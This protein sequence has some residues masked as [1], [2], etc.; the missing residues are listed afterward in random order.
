MTVLT[1]AVK[2]LQ[3]IAAPFDVGAASPW[4]ASSISSIVAGARFSPIPHLAEKIDHI[5]VNGTSS[6][7]LLARNNVFADSGPG[8]SPRRRVLELVRTD[9]LSTL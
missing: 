8:Y 4:T 9:P 2:D 6:E 1:P 5:T 3:A 7:L